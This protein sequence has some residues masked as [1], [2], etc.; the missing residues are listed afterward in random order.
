MAFHRSGSDPYAEALGNTVDLVISNEAPQLT[1][2]GTL[3][4]I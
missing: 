3:V 4:T 1:D 2:G